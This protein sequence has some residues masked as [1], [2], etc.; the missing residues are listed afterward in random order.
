LT[1]VIARAF[2]VLAVSQWLVP[3]PEARRAILPGYLRIYLDHAL[4][5]GLVL[6]TPPAPP[7][8]CGYLSGRASR[9]TGIT[10]GLPR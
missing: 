1:R 6:T 7:P 3:G 2:S 10:T 5:D 9:P 8:P 4:A